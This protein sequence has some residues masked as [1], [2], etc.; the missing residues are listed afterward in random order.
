MIEMSQLEQLAAFADCGTLSGAAE[1]LHISQPTLTR[2]M[3]K[4]EGAFGV[5]LFTHGKNRLTL[6]ENGELA[7]EH[8]KKILAQTDDMVRLVQAL[9]KASRT[10]SIGVCAPMPMFFLLQQTTALFPEKTVSCEIKSND[11]LLAGLKAETYQLIVLPF[12][13]EDPDLLSSACGTEQLLFALSP[14]HPFAQKDGLYMEEINGENMLLLSEIGFWHDIC[15]E[16]MPLSRFLIQNERF[17]FDELVQSSI[18]P[19]FA[20]DWTVRL[21]GAPKGRV[22]VPVL[23]PEATATYYIVCRKKEK[24]Q[25]RSLLQ[26]SF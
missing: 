8:A 4:L 25:L 14:D 2:A 24:Q 22:L 12:A 9:D 6:N 17:D 18:L 20:S 26:I 7:V 5:P 3:Q 11:E 10:L 15:V 1:M 19:S 13:P 23:D 16:K 21:N